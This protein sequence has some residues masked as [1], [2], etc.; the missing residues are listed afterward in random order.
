MVLE[1]HEQTGS[2]D[3][4][5]VSGFHQRLRRMLSFCRCSGRPPSGCAGQKP[6]CKEY[7]RCPLVRPRFSPRR[8]GSHREI[9]ALGKG[10]SRSIYHRRPGRDEA[11]FP[12][13]TAGRPDRAV[14]DPDGAL[15]IGHQDPLRW[16]KRCFT[17]SRSGRPLALPG[18][19]HLRQRQSLHPNQALAVHPLCRQLGGTVQSRL[20][21]GS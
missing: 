20:R 8:K 16:A 17:T 4:G 15:R 9:R 6:H 1:R 10:Q 3:S 11:R 19:K 12:L 7:D 18:Y 13:R 2:K 5:I 21:S 14:S